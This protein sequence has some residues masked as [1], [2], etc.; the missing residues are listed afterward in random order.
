MFALCPSLRTFTFIETGQARSTL[1]REG[2]GFTLRH[3][4][5]DSRMNKFTSMIAG[6]HTERGVRQ[7][8]RAKKLGV[9]RV[10]LVD[11]LGS[12]N[13]AVA[14]IAENVANQKV[15]P[16]AFLPGASRKRP[17]PGSDDRAAVGMG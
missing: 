13:K 1:I 5:A 7:L 2:K 12:Q 8:R 10:E 11:T 9:T 15:L 4:L 17:K 3:G 6:H 14:R 16:T